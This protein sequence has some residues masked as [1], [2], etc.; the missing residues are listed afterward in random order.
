M[1]QVD[2][3]GDGSALKSITVLAEDTN[4]TPNTHIRWL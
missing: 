3:L 2:R 4:S 1:T